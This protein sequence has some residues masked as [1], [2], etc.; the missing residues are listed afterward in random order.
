MR[1]G[2]SYITD[3]GYRATP[4]LTCSQCRSEYV[5]AGYAVDTEGLCWECWDFAT[6]GPYRVTEELAVSLSKDRRHYVL[7]LTDGREVPL[8]PDQAKALVSALEGGVPYPESD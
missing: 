4:I 8:T 2:D 1:M 5:A 7:L 3:L 6:R